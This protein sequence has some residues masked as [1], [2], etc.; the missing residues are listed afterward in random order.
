MR[1]FACAV[2]LGVLLAPLAVAAPAGQ[3][4]ASPGGPAMAGGPGGGGPEMMMTRALELTPDQQT[5]WQAERDRQRGVLQPLL[6]KLGAQMREL[7][8]AMDQKA[9]DDKIKAKLAELK[10][11]RNAIRDAQDK[12]EANLEAILNPTQQAKFTLWF[13]DRLRQGFG[14]PQ[15]MPGR[16]PGAMPPAR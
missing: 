14:R 3:V 4:P 8:E 15:T 1:K 10:A 9:P 5:R 7:K 2:V 13:A 6:E 12:H 11:T 16:G